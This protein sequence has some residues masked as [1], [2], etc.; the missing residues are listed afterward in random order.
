M[1]AR[2]NNLGHTSRKQDN[3]QTCLP[4]SRYDYRTKRTPDDVI[5]ALMS[6]QIVGDSVPDECGPLG[7]AAAAE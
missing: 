1:S 2:T 7:V 3:T 5:I 4:Q 6:Q